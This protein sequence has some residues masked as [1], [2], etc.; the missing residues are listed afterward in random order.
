MQVATNLIVFG[1]NGI[2]VDDRMSYEE[3]NLKDI[4]GMKSQNSNIH[5]SQLE[6]QEDVWP[7]HAHIALRR[8]L[9]QYICRIYKRSH[10]NIQNRFAKESK[11]Y[12][13]MA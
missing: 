12:A 10:Q 2:V 11:P 7:S 4:F 13:Y 3:S 9:H 6:S 5:L 1:A 8:A